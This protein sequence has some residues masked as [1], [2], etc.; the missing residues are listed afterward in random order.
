MNKAVTEAGDLLPRNLWLGCFDR[1]RQALRGLR[2]HLQ[3]SE[4]GITSHAV[5]VKSCTAA[6]GVL[7]DVPDA[8]EDV[9]EVQQISQFMLSHRETASLSTRSRSRG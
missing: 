2:P 1:L 5:R 6:C 7:L 4:H 8:L 3:I 9:I